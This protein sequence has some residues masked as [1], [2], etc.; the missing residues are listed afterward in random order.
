MDL[1]LPLDRFILLIIIA[2]RSRLTTAP[3]AEDSAENSM[4]YNLTSM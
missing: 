4:R 1:W 2:L 3:S